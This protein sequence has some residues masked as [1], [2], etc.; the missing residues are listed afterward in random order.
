M[1]GARLEAGLYL[2]KVQL[3]AGKQAEARALLTQIQKQAAA[4]GF[5][6][7]AHKAAGAGI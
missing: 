2:G 1:A 3:R 5:A 4:Q 7:I 6:L